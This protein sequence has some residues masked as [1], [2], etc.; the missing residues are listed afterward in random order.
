MEEAI[1]IAA[2][3]V[4]KSKMSAKKRLS[5]Q[6]IHLNIK[7]TIVQLPPPRLQTPELLLAL[8][9]RAVGAQNA[10]K[11]RHRLVH[12]HHNSE[13]PSSRGKVESERCAEPGQFGSCCGRLIAVQVGGDG[14]DE[15]GDGA[16]A[17]ERR[18][19]FLRVV[20]KVGG[21][22]AGVLDRDLAQLQH[23]HD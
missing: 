8:L 9:V 17:V 15:V 16:G 6:S 21:L 22:F 23:G 19:E 11:T 12:R 5:Q 1:M 20:Q 10:R 14:H 18:E 3:P 7:L 4:R 2:R 13:R